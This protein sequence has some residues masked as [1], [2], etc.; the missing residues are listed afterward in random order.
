[1]HRLLAIASLGLLSACASPFGVAS[2]PALPPMPPWPAPTDLTARLAA[3]GLSPV[4]EHDV[5]QM[6]RVLHLDVYYQGQPVVVPA[7]IGLA[8]D[9]SFYSPVHTHT[10]DGLV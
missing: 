7:N 2:T 8:S 4:G 5:I 3:A 6:L 9:P 1:M 10:G